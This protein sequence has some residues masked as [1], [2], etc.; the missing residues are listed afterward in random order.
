[1]SRRL[2]ERPCQGNFA[3]SVKAILPIAESE[4]SAEPVQVR[5]ISPGIA[6]KWRQSP[7]TRRVGQA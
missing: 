4:A 3:E 1:M 7:L 6:W 5:V 2:W